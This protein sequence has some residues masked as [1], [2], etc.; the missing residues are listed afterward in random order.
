MKTLQEMDVELERL[1]AQ[2]AATWGAIQQLRA[3]RNFALMKQAQET[4]RSEPAMTYQPAQWN[5]CGHSNHN[6]DIEGLA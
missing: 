4:A 6:F 3:E 2:H 5:D 1:S